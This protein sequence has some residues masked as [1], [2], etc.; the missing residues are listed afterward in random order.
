[1]QQNLCAGLTSA[2]QD[3]VKSITADTTSRLRQ[4]ADGASQAQNLSDYRLLKRIEGRAANMGN[5]ENM[6]VS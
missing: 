2:A 5:S 3:A 6:L 4:L 1:M